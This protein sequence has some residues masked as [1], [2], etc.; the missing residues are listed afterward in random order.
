[1]DRTDVSCDKM[2]EPKRQHPLPFVQKCA[3]LPDAEL[4]HRGV[5]RILRE[6]MG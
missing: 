6:E 1:M 5:H 4:S 3:Q 2:T